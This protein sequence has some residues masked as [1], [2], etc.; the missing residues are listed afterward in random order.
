MAHTISLKSRGE[1]HRITIEDPFLDEGHYV[2]RWS[3]VCG[4]AGVGTSLA[5][6]GSAEAA[7]R[8]AEQ[9][10]TD[11]CSGGNGVARI[12]AAFDKVLG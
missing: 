4:D 2:A 9:R 12:A 11:A 1:R 6:R 5:R 3:C 10:A 8:S 7:V